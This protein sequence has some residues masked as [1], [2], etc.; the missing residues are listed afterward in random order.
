[1]WEERT[2]IPITQL[3]TIIAVDN[4][5]PQVFIEHRDRFSEKLLSTIREYNNRKMF[6]R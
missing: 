3:V 5:E 4:E 6:G 1:M 2:G